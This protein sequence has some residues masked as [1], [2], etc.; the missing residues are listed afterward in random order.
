M[1]QPSYNVPSAPGSNGGLE[2]LEADKGVSFAGINPRAIWAAIYRSRYWVAGI[3]LGCLL[4]GVAGTLLVTPKYRAQSTVQIDQE[5]ER[6]IGTE[7]R[8]SVASQMDSERFLQTQLDVLRS[9]T[10]SEMVADD[11]NLMAKSATFFEAMDVNPKVKTTAILSPKDA[12]REK[13]LETLSKNLSVSIPLDSRVTTISFT[14]ADPTFAARV[15]NSY[16]ENYIRNNLQRKFDTSS[17]ARDF[18]RQQLDEARARLEKSERDALTYAR[19]SRLID[20]SNAAEVKDGLRQPPQSLT[21]ATLVQLNQSYAAAL[22]RRVEAQKKWESASSSNLLDIPQV[23]AND[24]VQR[25]LESRARL[26]ATLSQERQRRLDEFP[27]IQRLKAQ[28]NELDRQISAIANNIRRSIRADYTI[29]RGQEESIK[30]QLSELKGDTLNEQDK[31]VRLGILRR[32]SDTDRNLYDLLLK[33]FNEINAEAGVQSNN[34]M[35][36]DRA[37]T[38]PKP[39]SPNIP[40]NMALALLIGVLLSTIFMIVRERLFDTLRTPEQVTEI[41]GLSTLGVIPKMTEEEYDINLLRDPKSMLSEAYSSLRSSLSMASDHGYPKSL[42]FTSARPGEG[43]S[44]SSFALA[45]GL[46]RIGKKVIIIDL[47][48]RRPQQ[49]KLFSLPNTKGMSDVLSLNSTISD[50]VHRNISEGVDLIVAGPIPPNPTELLAGVN[51]ERTL[52][53]LEKI[54]DV[55]I[56]DGPPVM[57]LADAII[58]G[59]LTEAS[60]M[61]VLSAGNHAAALRGA[62]ARLRNGG[63][64]IIG[65]AL[66]GFDAKKSGY[67]YEY[68]YRYNYEA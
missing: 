53:E 28:L 63:A 7:Q 36:L 42:Q 32:A 31:S 13:V 54:Y 37:T 19:E 51:L 16:A 30:S 15:A 49:H 64:H 34:V 2:I 62:I 23:L 48:M 33:R 12:A 45:S 38:P 27:E 6:V 20:T 22:A 59:S 65:V 66:N 10:V 4:L 26:Q 11:L 57:G 35:L 52:A 5:T 61:V 41:L 46:G 18:L 68:A 25:L 43:K 40:L 55:I 1:A 14:S 24:A 47:D 17:Y 50:V 3:L 29:A 9:R 60:V 21:T 44:S 56:V 8:D 58:I 39:F 67:G